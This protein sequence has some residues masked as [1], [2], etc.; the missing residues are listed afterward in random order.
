LPA[1]QKRAAEAALGRSRSNCHDRDSGRRGSVPTATVS[2]TL[3]PRAPPSAA[4]SGCDV[5]LLAS[6]QVRWPRPNAS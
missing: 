2:A 5:R 4:G 1:A 6:M 3:R